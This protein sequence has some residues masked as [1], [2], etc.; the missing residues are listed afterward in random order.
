MIKHLGLS[1]SFLQK[2]SDWS[3]HNAL[4]ADGDSIMF[5]QNCKEVVK[6]VG[7]YFSSDCVFRWSFSDKEL[8]YHG[9]KLLIN[10]KQTDRSAT[11]RHVIL[12]DMLSRSKAK[13]GKTSRYVQTNHLMQCLQMI[14]FIIRDKEALWETRSGT[15]GGASL[16]YNLKIRDYFCSLFICDVLNSSN[17][18][19]PSPTRFARISQTLLTTSSLITSNVTRLLTS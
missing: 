17:F 11:L 16:C 2:H 5:F 19:L 15:P 1:L 13:A 3:L 7:C 18:N 8:K 6:A 4:V 9:D 10:T 12:H 14:L